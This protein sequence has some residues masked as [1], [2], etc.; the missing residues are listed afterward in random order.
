VACCLLSSILHKHCHHTPKE[1]PKDLS[2]LSGFFF[3]SAFQTV[4]KNPTIFQGSEREGLGQER[5]WRRA[6]VLPMP[7]SV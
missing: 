6:S 4:R 3:S 1:K 5:G 7:T 2:G